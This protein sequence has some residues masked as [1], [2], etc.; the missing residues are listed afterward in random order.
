MQRCNTDKGRCNLIACENQNVHCIAFC[1][2]T[3][4]RVHCTRQFNSSACS[5]GLFSG[6]SCIVI[7]HR[8]RCVHHRAQNK[9]TNSLFKYSL[10]RPRSMDEQTSPS[11]SQPHSRVQIQRERERDADF[12]LISNIFSDKNI[13]RTDARLPIRN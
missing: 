7:L 4:R 5:R 11:T 6:A 8:V 1:L 10:C 3:S 2:L 12:R 9:S 13:K